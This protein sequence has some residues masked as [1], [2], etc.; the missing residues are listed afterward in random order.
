MENTKAN[1]NHIIRQL[2]R[3]IQETERKV[4]PDE[5]DVLWKS[6]ERKAAEE[7]MK[8]RHYRLMTLRAV[9]AAAF[10]AGVF[11]IGYA[12]IHFYHDNNAIS[13]FVLQTSAQII[14]SD[15]IRL[16][17][18]GKK[19]IEVTEPDANISYSENGIITIN[20]DTIN[21]GNMDD[22]DIVFNQLIIPKGKRTQLLLADGTRMWVNSGTR[23]VYPS[24]FEKH[25]REIYV[26][27]E[28]YLD[29]FRDEKAP[30]YV[31]TRD[32]QVKVLGTS[33][34]ISAYLSESTSSVVLVQGCVN[35]KNKLD[36]EVQLAPG[37]LVDITES[38]ITSPKKVDVEPYICWMKN[39]LMYTNESLGKVFSRLN[40]YY[41]MEFELDSEV[42]LMR[43]SGKLDLKEKL[44][45]V[46]HT[47]AFSV[48][49]CYEEIGGRVIVKK[50]K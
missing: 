6:I 47:I 39:M 1:I 19:D 11:W 5:L 37:Q 49:I 22:E 9:S 20:A 27:G 26:E 38:V 29:V 2:I 50:M 31:K 13:R 17:I 41:G 16:L 14:E 12:L 24:R 36:E 18:P 43:V 25:K 48:P 34:N 21:Q 28:V 44:E 32:F 8:Q 33:F 4:A 45:D 46:L 42:A 35:V 10:L 30:F 15:E 7:K 23:I 3:N 40:L